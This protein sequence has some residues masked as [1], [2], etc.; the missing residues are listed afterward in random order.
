MV[1]WPPLKIAVNEVVALQPPARISAN[2]VMRP[3]SS[4]EVSATRHKLTVPVVVLTA[5]E[6]DDTPQA[7]A[8]MAGDAGR[9]SVAVRVGLS[10]TCGTPSTS[11]VD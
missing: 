6:S 1:V 2:G 7:K 5:G 10:N 3:F 11:H 8:G 9:P 4:A